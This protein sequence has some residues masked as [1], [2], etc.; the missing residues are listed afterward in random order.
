MKE[1]KRGGKKTQQREREQKKDKELVSELQ[2]PKATADLM[3]Q[4]DTTGL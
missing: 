4:S 1:T 3:E 2:K